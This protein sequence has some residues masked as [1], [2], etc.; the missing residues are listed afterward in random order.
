MNNYIIQKKK[1]IFEQN[2]SKTDILY[3]DILYKDI[4]YTDIL[5]LESVI[6]ILQCNFLYTLI[7]KINN[8][9]NYQNNFFENNNKIYDDLLNLLY[10]IIPDENSRNELKKEEFYEEFI[11]YI[12]KISF[13]DSLKFCLRHSEQKIESMNEEDK[14][15]NLSLFN[16]CFV[17]EEYIDFFRNL[18]KLFCKEKPIK[19]LPGND[20]YKIYDIIYIS[21]LNK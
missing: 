5:Y 9:E 2:K 13:E 1:K 3:T 21:I 17:K 14:E 8:Q 7:D 18:F 10:S 16:F 19:N 6:L 4:I 12:A 15:N 20:I 11:Y